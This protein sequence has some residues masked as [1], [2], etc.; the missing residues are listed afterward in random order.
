MKNASLLLFLTLLL[1]SPHTHAGVVMELATKNAAGQ[2]IRRTSIYAQGDK[3]RMDEN[4]SL[5]SMIFLGDEFLV[6]DHK[7]KNYVVMDE[8]MLEQVNTQISAAMQEM[9]AQLANMPPAQRA[10]VKEM[11]QGQMQGLMAQSGEPSPALRVEA[12]GTGE[13]KSRPCD[14]Y[15][16]FEGPEKT[17]EICAIDFQ[18]IE[19]GEKM[20]QAF[21]NMA[22]FVTK[23]TESMPMGN[24]DGF[25]PGELMDQISG[26]PVRTLEYKNGVV[27]AEALLESV[28]E[29]D[30]DENLFTVPDGYARQNLLPPD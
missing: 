8:A 29:Q 6:L 4:S 2:E 3:V 21:R 17:Q 22:E 25:N 30:I 1:L 24:R 11:M 14:K 12:T 20:M 9:E 13:W 10:M 19:G 7:K 27:T 28:A 15:A 18:E 26:F 23:M 5:V 16:V